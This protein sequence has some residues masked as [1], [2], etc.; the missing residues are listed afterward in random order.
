MPQQDGRINICPC[1]TGPQSERAE[2]IGC[3]R[4]DNFCSAYF[5]ESAESRAG[6]QPEQAAFGA[7]LEQFGQLLQ[8]VLSGLRQAATQAIDEQ[9]LGR[10]LAAEFARWL[11]NPALRPPWWQHLQTA[12]TG[13]PQFAQFAQP[14]DPR[15]GLNMH[16]SSTTA[17]DGTAGP[18]GDFAATGRRC[19]DLL[20]RQSQLQAKL[21]MLWGALAGN[22]GARFGACAAAGAVAPDLT[23]IREWYDTWIECA[24]QA[25]AQTVHSDE[26]CRTQAEL[27]NIATELLLTQRAQAERGARSLGLPTRSEL[28]GLRDQ[29]RQLQDQARRGA[30]RDRSKP[31]G[32]KRKAR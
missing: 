9:Q 12:S 27:F 15:F 4:G 11:S 3:W 25:Y 29:I 21:T 31:S 30:A 24:E 20:A 2:A 1:F 23:N 10:L 19:L 16:S 28:D 14:F 32:P 17:A 7:A 26:F 5:M 8:N 18:V 13:V 22:A 6:T